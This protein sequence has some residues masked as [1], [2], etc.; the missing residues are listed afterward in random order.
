LKVGPKTQ[1][2]LNLGV[3]LYDNIPQEGGGSGVGREC[4]PLQTELDDTM[5]DGENKVTDGQF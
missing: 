2:P 3:T 5:Q 1:H 4:M